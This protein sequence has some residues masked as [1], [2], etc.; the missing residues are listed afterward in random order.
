[1]KIRDIHIKITDE[2]YKLIKD[3]AVKEYRKVTQVIEKAIDNY[4]RAKKILPL[5]CLTKK[6]K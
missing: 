3:L 4:L 6:G 1:M 5:V 2:K